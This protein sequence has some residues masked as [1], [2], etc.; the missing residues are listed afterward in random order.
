MSR[1][2]HTRSGGWPQSPQSAGSQNK[3][4]VVNGGFGADASWTK[5]GGWTIASGVATSDGTQLAVSNLT[6]T[7]NNLGAGQSYLVTFAVTAVSAGSVTA[8][9]GDTAGTARTAVGE[10]TQLLTQT[11]AG[12]AILIQASEDFVGS[13][14]NFVAITR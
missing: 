8:Y 5:G 2:S 11:G 13:I 1:S 7:T 9:V 10:Y 4:V 6:Q 12:L 14:D 3:D